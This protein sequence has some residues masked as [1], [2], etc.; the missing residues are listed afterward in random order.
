M[1]VTIPSGCTEVE[2]RAVRNLAEHAG[3]RNIYMIY[4]S[5]AAAI[6]LGI[7]VNAPDGT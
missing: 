2:R 1:V 6:G 7:D 4:E 3:G 5:M